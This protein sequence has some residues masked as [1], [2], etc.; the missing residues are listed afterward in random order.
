MTLLAS[1]WG[2]NQLMAGAYAALLVTVLVVVWML[3]RIT[4]PPL[5]DVLSHAALHN[6][7]FRTFS[8]GLLYVR[9]VFY[10]L[11]VT[12]LFGEAAVRALAS[13]RW[14]Q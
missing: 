9:D 4:G 14:R 2:R 7:H 12:V 5:A 3:A 11:G 6:L 1:V 8:H 13:W 10:Y